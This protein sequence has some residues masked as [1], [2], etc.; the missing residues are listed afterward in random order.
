MHL[1]YAYCTTVI[2][3]IGVELCRPA[4]ERVVHFC[5][6]SGNLVYLEAS[7]VWE[8]EYGNFSWFG[9][10]LKSWTLWHVIDSL[11]RIDDQSQPQYVLYVY[12]P[13]NQSC[14]GL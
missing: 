4:V 14:L 13:T 11:F 3:Q 9:D 1:T 5:G 12:V 2:H 6:V 10:T 8:R 7:I